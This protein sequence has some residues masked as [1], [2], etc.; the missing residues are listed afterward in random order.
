MLL[1]T[2]AGIHIFAA[3]NKTETDSGTDGAFITRESVETIRILLI[4]NK[5]KS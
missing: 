3:S 5:E 1:H 4:A 2:L